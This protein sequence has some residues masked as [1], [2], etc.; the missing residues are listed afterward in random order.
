[1][2]KSWLQSEHVLRRFTNHDAPKFATTYV[3]LLT[4]T[5]TASNP[6]GWVEWREAENTPIDRIRVFS[7][8]PSDGTPYWSPPASEGDT[9]ETH[10]INGLSWSSSDT[11]TLLDDSQV[12]LG[13][14]V[15]TT[16][17][18]SYTAGVP[19]SLSDLIYW[20]TF[21]SSK[22][23]SEQEAVVFL[24]GGIKITEQ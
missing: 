11:A 18:T 20:N 15:F 6:T 3:G 9:Y 16:A 12:I 17:S 24:T 19:D 23:V 4:A 21:T 10:N 13:A 7:T 2:P 8:D 14:G 5:P 22:T 1:M